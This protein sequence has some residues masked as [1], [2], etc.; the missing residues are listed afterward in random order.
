MTCNRCGLVS[1]LGALRCDC[2]NDLSQP[3][4]ATPRGRGR[5][6]ARV[7]TELLLS[8]VGGWAAIVGPA[9]NASQEYEAAFMPM[10]RNA[11]EGMSGASPALLFG[12]GVLL[13]AVGRSPVVLLGV[14]SVATFPLWSAIDMAQGG[15]HNLFPIEWFIYAALAAFTTAGAFLGRRLRMRFEEP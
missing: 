8:V 4:S 12:L 7:G 2:G 6:A 3:Q 11:V 13:G 14:A 1:P 10:M 15:D 9:G 5:L